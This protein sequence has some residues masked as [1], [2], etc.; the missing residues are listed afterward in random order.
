[1]VSLYND[2]GMLLWK[3]EIHAGNS[4][5]NMQNLAKSIYF[6]KAVTQVEKVVL[7]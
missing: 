2:N 5:G 3:K 1:M 6:L 7:K 4:S